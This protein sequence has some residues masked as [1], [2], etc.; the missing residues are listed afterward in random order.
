VEGVYYELVDGQ[1]ELLSAAPSPR[2]QLVCRALDRVISE[3]CEES[4]IIIPAPVDVVFDKYNTREP[5]LVMIHRSRS[6]I[7]TIKAIMGVP[8][9]VVETLSPYSIRRDRKGKLQTYARFGVPEF[10]IVDPLHSVLEQYVLPEGGQ[11]YDLIEVYRD[12]EVVRSDKLECVSFTMRD[13]MNKVP[14][15]PNL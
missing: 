5:D 4:Y 10:W 11:N 3:T 2:H 15:L 6:S 9:L 14:D 12:D 8:D 1:L 7:I 13:V